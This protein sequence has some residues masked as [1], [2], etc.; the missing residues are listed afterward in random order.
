MSELNNRDRNAYS[1]F[2]HMSTE[3]LET[4]LRLDYQLPEG[5][6]LDPDTILAITEVIANREESD[7]APQYPDT[8]TAWNDFLTKYRPHGG[9]FLDAEADTVSKQEQSKSNLGDSPAVQRRRS[10][11]W[12]TR[13]ALVAAIIAALL[14]ATT[15]TASAFGYDLWNV[16]A[17]WTKET[18]TFTAN[19]QVDR[20]TPD[21]HQASASSNLEVAEYSSLQDAL[22][23]YGISTALA[24]TWIPDRF[25]LHSISVGETSS[26]VDFFAHYTCGDDVLFLGIT[27]HK[28][29][30]NTYGDWQKDE[31]NPVPYVTNGITHYLMTNLDKEV[32]VWLNGNYECGI[33]GDISR[34]ELAAIIESIYEGSD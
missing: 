33:T 3:D 4:I 19:G 18:F 8:D 12:L 20:S 15:V 17:E 34:D 27:L 6:G 9:S 32:A 28:D 1:K 16:I 7:S 11:R 29:V 31:S 22:D 21:V 26:F 13:T 23:G 14:L 25:E 24:P 5:E 2:E 10:M 30:P